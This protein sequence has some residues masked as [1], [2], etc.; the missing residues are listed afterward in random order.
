MRS[1]TFIVLFI[2]ICLAGIL[3]GF[4]TY[5][6]ATGTR[7]CRADAVARGEFLS[8]PAFSYGRYYLTE[9]RLESIPKDIAEPYKDSARAGYALAVQGDWDKL[10]MFVQ[11]FLL[12]AAGV[13]GLISRQHPRVDDQA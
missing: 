8:N 11:S 9:T 4:N 7:R 5:L 6:G 1:I 12:V 3:G 10:V 13:T 2:A